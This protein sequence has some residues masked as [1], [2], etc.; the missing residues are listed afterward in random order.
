[1]SEYTLK[2]AEQYAGISDRTLRRHIKSG[3]LAATL[4]DGQYHISEED[5]QAIAKRKKISAEAEVPTFDVPHTDIQ[6]LLAR[7]NEGFKSISD[8]NVKIAERYQETVRPIINHYI[9]TDEQAYI[10]AFGQMTQ[11][12]VNNVIVL[13]KTPG[14]DK[15]SPAEI[16]ER[17]SRGTG[18][19]SQVREQIAHFAQQLSSMNHLSIPAYSTK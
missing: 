8:G 19:P 6:E 1:M 13:L 10:E 16:S 11:T 3:K 15:L 7:I 17:V 12:M 9:S 14:I 4:R 18:I 5:L 2:E